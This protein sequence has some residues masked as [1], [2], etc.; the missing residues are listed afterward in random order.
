MVEG[1]E[2]IVVGQYEDASLRNFLSTFILFLNEYK[3]S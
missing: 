2:G 3:N 1:G